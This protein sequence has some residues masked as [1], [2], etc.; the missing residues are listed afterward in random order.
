[1]NTTP[2]EKAKELVEKFKSIS[3]LEKYNA[4]EC[5]IIAAELRQDA[6]RNVP[7]P[8]KYWAE[9]SQIGYWQEVKENIKNMK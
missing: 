6:Y 4:K 1:M 9:E 5:A 3:L 8:C 7:T 2:E